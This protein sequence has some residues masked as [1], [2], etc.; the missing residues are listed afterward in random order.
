MG[1]RSSLYIMKTT[2]IGL[3]FLKL[4]LLIEKP[5]EVKK[6]LSRF[7]IMRKMGSALNKLLYIFVLVKISKILFLKTVILI[8]NENNYNNK[9]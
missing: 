2:T 5:S 4:I 3:I 7:P 8:T 6:F 1:N 9:H